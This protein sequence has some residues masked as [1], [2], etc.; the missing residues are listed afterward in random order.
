MKL[1]KNT[2]YIVALVFGVST[3]MLVAALGSQKLAFLAGWDT[4]ALAVLAL[5]WMDFHDKGQADTERLAKRDDMGHSVIDVV[6]T[7]ASLAS[8][9]SVAILM[10]DKNG[11]L[12]EIGFGVASIIVSWALI[13]SLYSL[14]YAAMYYTQ[15]G[16]V[17]F[18][19]K[20]KPKFSDFQ[21]LAFT[22][23]MTYQVSDTTF[24]DG[25]FRKV[26]L[27]HAI[28]SFVFGTAIIAT[29]INFVAS[30]SQ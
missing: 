25:H 6:V 21:Y 29:T 13:H 28:L 16:G 20:D 9:G 10:A 24:T 15:G 1:T 19:S 8:I 27:R 4:F 30:L 2:R 18:S 17:D 26:A 12:A 3:G 14:R 11:G 23:G 22:I 7:M 5:L